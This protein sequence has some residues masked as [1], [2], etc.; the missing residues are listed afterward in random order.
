MKLIKLIRFKGDMDSDIELVVFFGF[1]IAAS[2]L[3]II[4][5]ILVSDWATK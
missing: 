2:N 1:W 5:I 4:S 3:A